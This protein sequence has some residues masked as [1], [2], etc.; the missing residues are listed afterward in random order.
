MGFWEWMGF[1]NPRDSPKTEQPKEGLP[2]VTDNVRD[3]GQTFVFGRSNAGEQVDEKAAM[4]IPTVYACVRLLAESIAA[5][6]LHLYRVTD[7][8]GNKEKARDHPLYKILYRQPNPEMT[9]FVFWETLM[10]HLL[11]WGNAY[12]KNTVLGLYPLLPENVEVDRDESGELYYIYHAYTD[13]VPGEQNKDLYFRRDE[14]F[15]VPGLG[16]N[17]LI[18]FSPIAMM[19]NSLGTS[20]SVDKYGSS[21]FK[22]GAQPSGVLEDPGVV[23]DPNRIRDSWEAAYGGAANAHRVAVLEEGMAY[24]P[25]SLPPEDSQFLETKQFSVTE[26]CR[27][28]RVPPHLVADLSRAT[29]SNIEYQSLNFVM[30]SLTPWLV[31]IEQGI[32]KDLLLEEDLPAEKRLEFLKGISA[33]LE[34]MQW[35]ITTLLKISKFDAGTAVLHKEP[36]EL[37]AVVEQALAPFIIQAELRQMTLAVDCRQGQFLGDRLWT[38]EAVQNIV[39]NCLE[40][41]DNGGTLRL[42]STQTAL[43]CQLVIADDGCGIEKEDLPHIFERFYKGKNAGADSVG[44]GL[45]LSKS[46]LNRENATVEVQSTVGVGTTFTIRFYR[47]II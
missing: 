13:E 28:F 19:K 5:L 37:A 42:T 41:M 20:I 18:G 27:I 6:P 32:I 15:H 34:K 9:S 40:H 47:N 31:R 21:F 26:I 35:M 36:V 24:K 44:I 30:H 17:G 11:L 10:T 22:N 1:E 16:F 39:K 43:Y 38:V 23:K 4:Q 46:V 3:S 25:I 7:D 12:G 2:Q 45:A 29:F 33:Q 8:N 14:I